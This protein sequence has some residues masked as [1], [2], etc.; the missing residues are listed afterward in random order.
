MFTDNRDKIF[1]PQNLF[2]WFMLAFQGGMINAG[3]YMAVHRF[4]SH[5]TGF[6]TLFGIEFF[7]KDITL[8]FGMLMGPLFFLIGA[9]IS[10]WFIERR[11]LRS[12]Y[13]QYGIVFSFIILN[14]ILV[15]FGGHFGFFGQFGE[16]F[17]YGRDYAL[18]FILSLTCGLQN[19]VIS[20]VSGAIIRTTHLTGP[21]T[22]LG[23]GLVHLWTERHTHNKKLIFATW[24]RLGIITSFIIGSLF[25]AFIFIKWHFLGFISPVFISL[26]VMY[27]LKMHKA[28]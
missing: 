16:E 1:E 25:G 20:S 12:Y 17:N 6:A 2:I 22:D 27:R 11:R 3:G 28:L 26:F 5:V 10:A 14:L 23:I 13:P 24:C 8:A 7:Q 18:L 15:S 9:M 21:T 4:V 19:A